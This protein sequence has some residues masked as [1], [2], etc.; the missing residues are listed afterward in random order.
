[1]KGTEEEMKSTEER[2]EG[3]EGTQEPCIQ[4]A[5]AG[6]NRNAAR[7]INETRGITRTRTNTYAQRYVNSAANTNIIRDGYFESPYK[8]RVLTTNRFYTGM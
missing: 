6:K 3:M 2:F 1:M 5:V 7:E 8:K 4:N